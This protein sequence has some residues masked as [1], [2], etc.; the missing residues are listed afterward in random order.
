MRAKVH[1]ARRPR[2]HA[3]PRVY[4]KIAL[5]LFPALR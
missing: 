5:L 1:I 4:R 2:K 3:G